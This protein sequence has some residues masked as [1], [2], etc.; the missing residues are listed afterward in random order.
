[1]SGDVDAVRV[2]YFLGRKIHRCSLD[3]IIPGIQQQDPLTWHN[4]QARL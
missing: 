1:M 3:S 4:N 2:L